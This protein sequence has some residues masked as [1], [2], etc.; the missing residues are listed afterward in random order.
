MELAVFGSIVHRIVTAGSGVVVDRNAL[1]AML[2]M[3]SSM[4]FL[5]VM[6]VLITQADKLVLSGVLPLKEYG[7]FSFAAIAA[8]G[9][10][11]LVPP[12]NQVIQPRLTILAERHDEVAF[13]EL[14]RL[15][16]QLVV[17]AFV[18]LGGALAFF[19]EPILRIWSGNN[20]MAAA[21]APILFWYALANALVGILVP[22]FMLQFAKGQLRLHILG[23]LILLMTL[24]PALI[25][26]ARYWGAVGAGQVFFV[27]NLLF[28]LFWVPL[29]HQHILPSVTTSQWLWRDTLPIALVTGGV[30]AVAAKFLPISLQATQTLAWIGLAAIVA[31][32]LGV[33]AGDRS[34]PHVTRWL[35]RVRV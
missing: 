35:S 34:R 22:P 30:F 15:T 19:A 33:V 14:Y 25:V 9:V 23:N 3:V 31:V 20:E 16:S 28:L 1:S 10:L 4:A 8:S 21:A 11:V 26:A 13:V 24:L 32:T 29:V 6:W 18:A 7:Y 17:I 12:L 27:A 2:P 5:S